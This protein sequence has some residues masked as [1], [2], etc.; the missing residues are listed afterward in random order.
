MCAR[1]LYN[2]FT[3]AFCRPH[4]IRWIYCLIGRYHHKAF[5]FIFFA[6][7][8]HILCTKYIVFNCL[9][10]IMFHQ[11]HMFMCSCINYNLWMILFKH[12]C[13]RLT[14]CNQCYF[15]LKI[16]FTFISNF[17]FLLHIICTIFVNIQNY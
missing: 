16:Q 13:H 7:I 14:I 8:Y 9:N 5:C 2:H 6:K 17:Q 11:W 1:T 10:T 15:H 12:S 3:H 4:H